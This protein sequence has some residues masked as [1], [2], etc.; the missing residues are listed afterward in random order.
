MSGAVLTVD[1]GA[2]ADN[3]RLLQKQAG[4]VEV[5]AVVKANAYGLGIERIGPHLS[6]LGARR[7]L[8][9][10]ISEGIRLRKVVP[11]AEILILN[12][13]GLSDVPTL[14]AHDLNPVLNGP[15]QIQ[16]WRGAA[17]K[18]QSWLQID[19]GMNRAGIEIADLA[20]CGDLGDLDL[21]MVMSHLATAEE[22]DHALTQAQIATFR[23]VVGQFPG[24]KLS[25]AN[26][27]ATLNAPDIHF[28]LVRPGVALYGCSN[29]LHQGLRTVAALTA[30]ILQLRT[31]DSGEA[32]GY[33]ATHVATRT[34]QIA[35]AA[36]GYADGYLRALSNRGQVWLPRAGAFA[37]LAGRVSMD[38]TTIDVTDL[39]LGSVAPGDMIE[40]YGTNLDVEA[41]AEMAGT[42]SYELMA[43]LTARPERTYK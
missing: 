37:P 24:K 8:V 2:L 15:E 22:P 41:V 10:Q 42:I 27:A 26:S 17:R 39:P 18:R 43:G 29:S 36:I 32:V 25:L 21:G 23:E 38:L 34:S 16:A 4:G 6:S 28:D 30:P 20:Q 1:L 7:F 5:A 13:I 3:W 11:E 31:I 14:L 9:A 33:G 19:T 40:F 12:G 35:T